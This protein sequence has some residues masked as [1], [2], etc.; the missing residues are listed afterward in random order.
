MCAHNGTHVDAPSHFIR[1]GKNIDELEL[2]SFV[3]YAY[4]AF[5]TGDVTLKDARKIFEDAARE[6]CEA[7]RRILVKGKATLTLEAAEFFA[8][9]GILLY[10]NESQTV[11]PE[12]APVEVHKALLSV[13]TV[14]LEGIRLADV[15]T[16][17]YLLCAA[18]LC[19]ASCEGA[20]CRAI[21]IKQ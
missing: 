5:H 8:K 10:G 16:G 7:S 9:K 4:V 19:L 15:D 12:T 11:G 3:G 2:S 14:L 13:G 20:P 17:V 18:P 6:C 21:L 1:D